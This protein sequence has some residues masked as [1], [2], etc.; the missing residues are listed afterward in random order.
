MVFQQTHNWQRRCFLIVL[1]VFLGLG[2]SMFVQAAD[3]D[4]DTRQSEAV[5]A[6]SL[7]NKAET[8]RKAG[9]L[10]KAANLYIILYDRYPQTLYSKDALWAAANLYK[11]LA[12]LPNGEENWEKA[13]EF[14]K[15]YTI[16]FVKS[17]HYHEA[18]FEA[19]LCYYQQ[20]R[21]REAWTQLKV[22]EGRFPS[23]PLI[24]QVRYWMAQAMLKLEKIDEA[25]KILAGLV[26]S[27]DPIVRLKAR[28]G[29]ADIL[30][31]KKRYKEAY[32]AYKEILEAYP[33][34]YRANPEVLVSLA[35]TCFQVESEEEGRSN[36]YRYLNLIDDKLLQARV[37]FDLG[38][39]YYRTGDDATAQKLYRQAIESGGADNRT[40]RLSKL[41]QAQYRDNPGKPALSAFDKKGD[42]SDPVGD[43]DYLAA[44]ESF[45][46]DPLAQD[47]R[48]NLFLRYAARKNFEH[49]NE[50][51]RE[52]L[53]GDEVK[54]G[55]ASKAAGDIL[56]FLVEELLAAKRYKDVYEL[57]R[58]EYRH[59]QAI[60]QGR[61]L[62]LV[63]QALEALNLYEQATVVYYRSLALSL[64]DEEKIGVYTRRV[65]VYLAQK[66]FVSADRLL[67]HLRKIYAG[68][69]DMGEIYFLSGR[70]S[71]MQNKKEE[72]LLYYD[73]AD[74]LFPLE[75]RRDELANYRL[76]LLFDLGRCEEAVGA[77]DKYCRE[78]SLTK[79]GLQ[80]WY[81]KL[82][83]YFFRKNLHILVL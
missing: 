11:S 56:M 1:C 70:M 80:Q 73:K 51:G 74:Q 4:K 10:A 83:D 62:Y 46:S 42:L 58:A 9:E 25:E 45:K 67:K 47:A 7:W 17:D 77:L 39:S 72:A 26:D 79:P 52:F 38:E 76:R 27:G 15:Q 66:D 3:S 14:F 29:Q 49:A 55:I 69:S 16:D 50:I 35:K 40:V 28:T 63:G 24:P 44:L 48:Y 57:Y 19:S 13:R 34:Y 36:L 23:S 68:G 54:N 78:G 65:I 60:K 21:Y 82:G 12:A 64:N 53:A 32:E 37:I 71:E 30:N 18:Y 22:F 43:Q 61:L 59:V 41:R 31:A 81:V 75:R 20:K 33:D 5:R 8:A 6:E 2:W